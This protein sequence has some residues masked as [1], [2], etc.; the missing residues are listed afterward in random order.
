MN[1]YVFTHHIGKKYFDINM[2]ANVDGKMLR[3]IED[4]YA[5]IL[6]DGYFA[7]EHEFINKNS[8]NTNIHIDQL[9]FNLSK[10]HIDYTGKLDGSFNILFY[11]KKKNYLKFTNDF[12]SSRPTY[13]YKGQGYVHFS[14]DLCFL[15]KNLKAKLSP[16]LKKI[17]ELLA[18]Q[19][20]DSGT[21]YYNEIEKLQPRIVLEI[22]S[23]KINLKHSNLFQDHKKLHEFSEGDFKTKFEKAVLNR[24]S[25]F[26]NIKVMLSGGLD[27]SA[28]AVALKNNSIH[29]I[30]TISVNFSHVSDFPE[31]DEK[32]YQ[33]MVSSY[34]GFK[35]KHI[36]M[37][38]KSVLGD[39]EK[40][41]HIF[42]EPMLIPNLYIFEAICDSLSK[43][44]AD[45]IFDGNDGDN[46]ISYGFEKVYSQF[47]TLNFL[48]FFY[49]V[50][51]YA[52]VHRKSS[53]K[54]INYFIKNS[55]KK[56]I[57][58]KTMHRNNSLLNDKLFSK[59]EKNKTRSIFDSH[60]SKLENNLHFIAFENRYKIFGQL[61]VEVVSPFYD[62]NLL[63]LCL[64]MPTKFKFNNGYTRYILRQYLSSYL[65]KDLSFR[66][67]KSNL[68]GGLV[69]NFS[70]YDHGIFI[71]ERENINNKLLEMIDISKL[72]AISDKWH[73]H[74]EI[75]EED[76]INLQIFININI[77]LNS[78]FE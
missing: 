41:V 30:E 1:S 14:N 59:T 34:T 4:D 45:A 17:Q 23:N 9:L 60:K 8:V 19:H 43:N 51:R 11:D 24:A 58:F 39:I 5:F 37:K 47:I 35:K 3:V 66:S 16:N 67:D 57:G 55:L 2:D 53:I 31:I 15:K 44:Q 54:M 28:V 42:Q 75:T 20:I 78:F 64:H 56:L 48:S 13:L 74:K 61:G 29:D 63:N 21:T 62:R 77:F 33:D 71:N 18:W 46:V 38:N 69:A 73:Q 49:S 32:K 36:E 72:D 65:P 52:K 70:D 50:L 26:K 10:M 27:S 6:I 76:I 25:K 68:A 12:W 40:Y 22:K 7:N